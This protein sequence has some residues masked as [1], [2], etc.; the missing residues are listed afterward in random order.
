M[1]SRTYTDSSVEAGY[2]SNVIRVTRKT[3]LT[4]VLLLRITTSPTHIPVIIFDPHALEISI[5]KNPAN[6][7]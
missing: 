1:L 6:L 5:T 2:V 4:P 7:E 3:R